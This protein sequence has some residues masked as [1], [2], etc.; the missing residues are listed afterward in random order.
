MWQTAFLPAPTPVQAAPIVLLARP[1]LAQLA[2]TATPAPQAKPCNATAPAAAAPTHPQTA[3]GVRGALGAHVLPAI[4]PG[5][6][7][8]WA[9]PL[10]A[11]LTIVSAP[12]RKVAPV[13]YPTR[14]FAMARGGK[15]RA[16]A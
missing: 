2:M 3:T 4:K 11:A 1:T 13:R 10:A 5:P 14:R 6:A 8:V 16:E 9:R 12:P 7:A 15:C